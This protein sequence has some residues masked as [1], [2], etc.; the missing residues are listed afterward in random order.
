MYRMVSGDFVLTTRVRVT[1]RDENDIPGSNYSLGGV[2]VRNPS[3][4]TTGSAGWVAGQEDYI[5][6]SIGFAATNH[7]TCQGCPGPHFEAKSTINSNSMLQVSSVDT[8]EAIIRLVRLAPYV[9]VLYQFPGDPWVVHQ[10]YLRADLEDTL[11]AG[12]VTYTDWNKVFTYEPLF[13]NGHV[14]NEDLDPDPS[15]NPGMPFDPDVITRYDY[16]DFHPTMMPA[17]W[18]G[19]DLTDEGDVPDNAVLSFFGDVLPPPTAPAEKIWTGGENGSWNTPGNWLSN[20][21]PAATD[22]IWVRS[23]ACPQAFCLETPMGSTVT[24]GLRVD[25]NAVVTIPSGSALEVN[26]AFVNHGEIIVYGQL[27]I[28]PGGDGPAYNLGL[29]DCRGSGSVMVEE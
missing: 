17:A 11:Q 1:N 16:F 21:V 23:C 5:F 4:L 3:S 10:R 24:T 20:G 14:L 22:S 18:T 25:E 9:L 8:N 19:L 28:T 29:I 2:M 26:G 12:M 7:P 15:S 27:I 13:H 6:L